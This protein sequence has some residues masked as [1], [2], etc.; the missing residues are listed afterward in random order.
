MKYLLDTHALNILIV[1]TAISES[2][3]LITSD[4][5]NQLYPVSWIWD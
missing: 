1:S 2:L 5:E 3:T 4:R